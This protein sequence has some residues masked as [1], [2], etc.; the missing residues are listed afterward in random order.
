MQ[1]HYEDGQVQAG[2]LLLA[3][4]AKELPE[5][6]PT[7]VNIRMM[8]GNAFLARKDY[9]RAAAFFETTLKL[10]ETT[11]NPEPSFVATTTGA[12]AD[13]LWQAGKQRRAL[14]VAK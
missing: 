7:L 12:Y 6:H 10:N 13:A 14:V 11:P 9:G 1:A 8:Q 4:L 5:G 3:E 2:Q